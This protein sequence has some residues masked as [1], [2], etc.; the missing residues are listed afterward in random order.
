MLDVFERSQL[1][2]PS[3]ACKLPGR[4]Q[5]ETV[6]VG[7]EGDL[8]ITGFDVRMT[9]HRIPE[10]LK[11]LAKRVQRFL[12]RH[13]CGPKGLLRFAERPPPKFRVGRAGG[14]GDAVVKVVLRT[15]Q[16]ESR[17]AEPGAGRKRTQLVSVC[18]IV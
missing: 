4:M 17:V 14:P 8:L 7:K 10:G 5:R 9:A 18:A 11:E 1:A 12:P 2:G 13:A 3:A 16:I 6:N 15:L